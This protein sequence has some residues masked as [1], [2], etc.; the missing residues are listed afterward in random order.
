M[1]IIK[2]VEHYYNRH[3]AD[4]YRM[5][6]L[7]SNQREYME[8]LFGKER[9]RDEDE[10]RRIEEF[11]K[12]NS[13]SFSE[14]IE[15]LLADLNH[16]PSSTPDTRDQLSVACRFLFACRLNPRLLLGDRIKGGA[17]GID[18]D[19]FMKGIPSW[20]SSAPP[21]VVK[22]SDIRINKRRRQNNESDKP[23]EIDGIYAPVGSAQRSIAQTQR[24]GNNIRRHPIRGADNGKAKRQRASYDNR[25]T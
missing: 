3:R 24:K 6:K 12:I 23:S 5:L 11:L 19:V 20:E 7:R 17:P 2:Q 4:A 18:V 8:G 14:R 22:T 10:G 9:E 16:D 13:R 15:C 25:N 1:E 21:N